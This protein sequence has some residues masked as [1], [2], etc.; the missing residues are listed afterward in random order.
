MIK[1]RRIKEFLILYAVITAIS[2]YLSR[3]GHWGIDDAPGYL[4]LIAFLLAADWFFFTDAA[5]RDPALL[6]MSGTKT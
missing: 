6:A 4:D 5:E 2:V 1:A 3:E